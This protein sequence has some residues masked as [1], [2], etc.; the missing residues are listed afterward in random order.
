MFNMRSFIV[1][2]N[3]M[4]SRTTETNYV[5]TFSNRTAVKPVAN[6]S[7]LLRALRLR[8]I[9]EILRADRINEAEMDDDM[10]IGEKSVSGKTPLKRTITGMELA[11]IGASEVELE[12]QYST[13]KFSRRVPRKSR[14]E[15]IDDDN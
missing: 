5:L 6:S 11:E 1:V 7:F 15:I 3:N 8:S 12:G 4:K 2:E 10:D 14:L 13:N 9:G